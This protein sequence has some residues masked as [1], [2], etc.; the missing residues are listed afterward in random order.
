MNSD[1]P[2]TGSGSKTGRIL[3]SPMI[4][5]VSGLATGPATALFGLL[6]ASC[7]FAG[8]WVA[9]TAGGRLGSRLM[10]TGIY[11][12]SFVKGPKKIRDGALLDSRARIRGDRTVLTICQITRPLLLR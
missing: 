12:H 4:F 3:K 11:S 7:A 6:S 5:R 1:L 2:L 10:I 8:S 9:S